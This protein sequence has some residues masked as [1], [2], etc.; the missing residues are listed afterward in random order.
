[1]FFLILFFIQS[2]S[3]PPFS[4]ACSFFRYS[5]PCSIFVSLFTHRVHTFS[6]S[7]AANWSII[8][9]F[10][11]LYPEIGCLRICVWCAR[12]SHG[13]HN[14]FGDFKIN[15]RNTIRRMHIILCIYGMDLVVFIFIHLLAALRGDVASEKG[16]RAKNDM[17]INKF[18]G[19]DNSVEPIKWAPPLKSVTST[20]RVCFPFGCFSRLKCA[21]STLFSLCKTRNFWSQ[22]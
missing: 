14:I 3:H 7:A 21:W 9:G 18:N 1:M 19:L 8:I 10:A 2:V 11:V 20:V 12:Y 22:I 15:L 16:R 13:N 5:R 6:S 17:N 4:S